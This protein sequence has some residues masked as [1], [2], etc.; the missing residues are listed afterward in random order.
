M[1][2]ISDLLKS[3]VYIS[4]LTDFGFKKIFSDAELIADI[5]NAFLPDEHIVDVQ[6]QPPAHL[7]DR[8]QNRVVEFD[9]YCHTDT[10]KRII[11]E[12]QRLSH[13]FFIDRALFYTAF[14]IREQAPK[15]KVSMKDK[16]GNEKK[17]PWNYEL[18]PVYFVGILAF[19][20][21]DEPEAKDIII[22]RVE[23]Y[24]TEAQKTCS[25]K[26]KMIFVELT[27]FNKT[28]EQLETKRDIWLYLLKHLPE[29][30]EMPEQIK[31]SD[32][33]FEKLFKRAKKS[34]LTPKEMETY[35]EDLL[36]MDEIYNIAISYERRGE[37]RGEARGAERGIA[38]G[39]ARGEA[40]G[41][42]RT[43]I[44]YALRLAQRGMS[45]V[46]IA[47]IT[48]LSIEEVKKILKQAKML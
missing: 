16:A 30:T 3:A 44:K 47:D 25:S 34:N 46:E 43:T 9:L 14:P 31:K 27:K 42:K 8:P 4:P 5:L 40:R 32:P 36:L 17:V 21:F 48:D 15:G 39:E 45:I 29:L 12:M 1:E 19:E 22:E 33:V 26:L 28:V 20:L 7:G 38:I 18:D 35:S 10:G 23:L 41:E 6:Y 2:K 11:I 24:R 37:A 13:D